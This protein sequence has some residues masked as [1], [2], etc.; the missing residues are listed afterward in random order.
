MD[1]EQ[2]KVVRL[3]FEE[4]LLGKSACRIGNELNKKTAW[5]GKI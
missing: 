5:S 3:I 1:E 2:A 4:F